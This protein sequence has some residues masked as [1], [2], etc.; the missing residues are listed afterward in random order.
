M[1]YVM[2]MPYPDDDR[3]LIY[4]VPN[5]YVVGTWEQLADSFEAAKQLAIEY[6][7]DIIRRQF[8][9]IRNMRQ[10]KENAQVGS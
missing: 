3:C 8:E 4:S 9:L 10:L 1:K 6:H 5:N 2:C 7:K